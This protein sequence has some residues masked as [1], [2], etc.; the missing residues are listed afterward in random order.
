MITSQDYETVVEKSIDENP[1]EVDLCGDINSLD[2]SFSLCTGEASLLSIHSRDKKIMKKR[3]T[4]EKKNKDRKKTFTTE[5]K[6][7]KL[8]TERNI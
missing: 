1:N 5:K 4:A 8:N 3:F 6:K 7:L 2:E